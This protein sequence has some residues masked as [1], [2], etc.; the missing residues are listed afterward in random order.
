MNGSILTKQEHA[1][2]AEAIRREE[3]RTSG[4]I[5]CVLARGSD[6]YFYPAAFALAIATLIASI[7][8]AIVIDRLWIIFPTWQ[9]VLAQL[10]AYGGALALI[11]WWPHLRIHFVPKAL[12]F[13]RAHHNA[14]TQFL[15]RNIHVT[16]NRT[17]VLIF[18]SLAERYA[19]IVADAAINAHVPQERW[20]EIVAALTA[21]AAK[22]EIAEGFEK[23]IAAT[24]ALLAAS[25][26]VG[27]GNTNELDD[28]LV[29]I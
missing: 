28:H 8:A 11:G 26:P 27:A 9:F 1:R 18:L 5:I 22:G 14:V 19:E 13:R 10:C 23:A 16:E 12:R 4:E 25:F 15:A 20:N 6:G 29:E 3:T 17:G 24:G 7:V 2:V 21:R